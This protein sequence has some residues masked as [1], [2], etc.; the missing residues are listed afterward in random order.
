M[1]FIRETKRLLRVYNI[2]PKK[3]LGQSFLI[4]QSLM[5][6]IV[7]YANLGKKDVV[8][9]VGAGLGFLTEELAERAKEVIAIEVDPKLVRVL[10]DRLTTYTNVRVIQGDF[11]NLQV[12]RFDKIVSN[13]PYS[14]SSP[15]IFKLLDLRFKLGV[16][17][18][19]EDFAKRLVADHGT[20]DYGRL[21]VMVYQRASVEVLE[22]V[23]KEAFYPIPKVGSS[24]VRISPLDRKTMVKDR[25]FF[26]NLV[27]ILFSQRKRTLRRALITFGERMRVDVPVDDLVINLNKRVYQLEPEEFVELSNHLRKKLLKK[28][29]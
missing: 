20:A 11:L 16:L 26:S 2:K 24:I 7:E 25:E 19:Q 17:T 13:P 5:K 15:F 9:D 27:N 3:W 4:S 6:R 10:E 23:P 28:H 22:R 8:L 14:I 29:Q 18:F 12:P 21:T 1:N